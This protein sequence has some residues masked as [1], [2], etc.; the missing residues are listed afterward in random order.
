M[1]TR[2]SGQ[3]GADLWLGTHRELSS[4]R[5]SFPALAVGWLQCAS[6]KCTHA[7]LPASEFLRTC[8]SWSLC[9]F[10]SYWLSVFNC[11]MIAGGSQGSM[12]RT[13]AQMLLP[14]PCQRRTTRTQH[15]SPSPG[16]SRQTSSRTSIASLDCW[17]LPVPALRISSPLASRPIRS[18][19]PM[20]GNLWTPTWMK[21]M[22]KLS[23]R[24]DT[25]PSG[26]ST[27]SSA[28]STGAR[29][30]APTPLSWRVGCMSAPLPCSPASGSAR[31]C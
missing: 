29:C 26:A 18:M 6:P 14:L 2:Q 15:R 25:P 20:F 23:Q 5:H 31:W 9:R 4:W 22:P 30:W 19:M 17:T 28:P 21:P 11:P 1:R 16:R 24:L 13:L 7:R 3:A 8:M 12:S 10:L 27:P